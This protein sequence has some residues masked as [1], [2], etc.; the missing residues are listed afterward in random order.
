MNNI[1]FISDFFLEQGVLGG[2]EK[3]ND[4]LINELLSKGY[5]VQKIISKS[6]KPQHIS[7]DV[8]YIISNFMTLD[9]DCKQ[10]LTQ[11][12]YIII[13]H[14]HKYLTTNDPSKFKNMIAPQML[15][16]N[17]Y[18]YEHAQAVYCQSR[19]HAE[20]LQKNIFLE[21]IINLGCNIWSDEDLSILEKF[22]DNEKTKENVVLYSSNK[23]KGTKQTSQFCSNKNISFEYIM[24]SDYE[25]FISNLSKAKTLY[26][27][28]QWLESFNRVSV[29]ARILG[30]KVV[31]NKLVGATSEPWF[32]ETKG[33]ELLDFVKEQRE[34]I[35][36]KFLTVLEEGDP[37]FFEYPK[38]PKVSIITS[39]Y[40]AGEYIEHFMS[41]VTKQTIFGDC[42]L[43]ILDA[44]SPDG[45]KKIVDKYLEKYDNIIYHRLKETL[46]V[47]ETMN[48]GL[49]MASGEYITLWNVDDTRHY[50]ALKILAHHLNVDTEIDLVYT[51][52]YQTHQK[53]E[54]FDKNTSRGFRYEHSGFDFSKRNMIKCLPGPL[55][56]WR[57]EMTQ[58]NGEFDESLKYAGDWEMWLRCVQA[59]SKFKR[60]HKILGL[61]YMNP[62]GLSTSRESQKE[63]F[64]E[65]REIFN[66]YKNVFGQE[67]YNQFKGYFNG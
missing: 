38:I 58:K 36:S 35:L 63:R 41:E 24:P 51:D 12:N 61:Y 59:G 6:F 29:E 62:D 53:N 14:D 1:V 20:T 56:M 18:F 33:R 44:N 28:P 30:C 65:E 32:K 13:E 43:I 64:K 15:V 34:V 10:R 47:Q 39:M 57:K 2:A 4:V 48:I 5:S 31:T 21:N 37:D 40:K 9:E 22:I 50:N 7:S 26:F 23:N 66:K 19:K 54:T 11:E 45:E 49:E 46:S 60:I 25:T 42:E 3:F 17:R 55:P 27:F 67:V 52:S 8:F 16:I